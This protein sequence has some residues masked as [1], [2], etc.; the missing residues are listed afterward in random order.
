M[1]R[2]RWLPGMTYEDVGGNVE[3]VGFSGIEI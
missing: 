2:L 3:R 1:L